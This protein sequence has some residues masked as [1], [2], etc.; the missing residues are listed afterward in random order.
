MLP[1][2]DERVPVAGAEAGGIARRRRRASPWDRRG[3]AQRRARV[4]PAVAVAVVA[5]LAVGCSS[6]GTSTGTST[7]T[8]TTKPAASGGTETLTVGVLSD[9]TGSAASGFLTTEQGIKAGLGL[10]TANGDLK[11]Y[12]V[13]YVMADTGSTPAG[14]LSAAQRLVQQDHVFAVLSVSSDTLGASNY[15][16]SQA[17]PV[18]GGGF[19]GPEWLSPSSTNMFST[20]GKV[21]YAAVSTTL[22]LFMK[23]QGV[24]SFG[25]LGYAGSP[26]SA[27]AVNGAAASAKGAGITAGY[28]NAQFPFGSTNVGPAAIAIKSAGVNGIYMPVVPSTGFAL[29]AALAQE[30][31]HPK[32]FLL[33]TGYG[34]DLLE[35]PAGV[36]AA[37]GDD[38]LTV[39]QP[40]EL[41]TAA[42]RQFQAAL[43]K[44][45]GVTGVP[46]FAEYEAYLSVAGLVTGLQKAG[47]GATSASFIKALGEVTDFSGFGLYGSHPLSFS[48]GNLG[49]NDGPGDCIYVTKLSGKTFEL[50]S[51]AE[52]ICGKVVA[53]ASVGT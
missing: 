51:G 32:V 4:M 5:G 18:V 42:T 1:F 15:L 30:G 39:A 24:T 12:N 40:V 43:A 53:G 38:F 29:G 19:D 46:T 8:S 49:G 11:G 31:V 25:G 37:Q 27:G 17:V 20:T 47:S 23:S 7:S 22:G 50:V 28:V 52:P 44:Y 13:K 36:A 9:L 34:G 48:G 10:A 21:N 35:S 2:D 33:A 3:R 14:A 45:A 16:T 6:S 41:N 26:S